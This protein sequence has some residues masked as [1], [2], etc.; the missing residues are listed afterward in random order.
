MKRVLFLCSGNYYRSRY[1]EILFNWHSHER[2]LTWQAESRGL[3]LDSRN[4]GPI[5]GY[6]VSRLTARGISCANYL[7]VPLQVSEADF[8][9][10]H[11]IIA[12]KEAEHRSIVEARFAAWRDLVEYWRIDD[13]DCATPE[14][15]LALLE[16]EI[17]GLLERLSAIAA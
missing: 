15:A 17:S 6:A 9:A 14:A 11:R 16:R 3:A 10:A 2:G 5:S 8:A 4:G 13:I 12:V 1:A 7:R